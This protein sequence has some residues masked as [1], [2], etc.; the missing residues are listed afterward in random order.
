M[1]IQF[2]VRDD[3][4]KDVR[5]FYGKDLMK[6]LLSDFARIVLTTMD[7]TVHDVKIDGEDITVY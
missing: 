4:A 6:R 1:K 5:S 3:F 2:E 7:E